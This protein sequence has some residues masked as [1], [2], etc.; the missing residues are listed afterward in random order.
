MNLYEDLLKAGYVTDKLKASMVQDCLE[1]KPVAG[2]LLRGDT[3]TGK[4]FL[5]YT[6][7][8]ILEAD[9]FYQQC[10]KNTG[11]EEL[12]RKILPAD[13]T[14]SGIKTTD[15]VI[16]QALK[17]S[18]DKKTI[19]FIDEIDK[20][21]PSCDTV[22]LELLQ[23]GTLHWDGDVFVG[24]TDNLTIFLGANEAR[25]LEEPLI[26][27]LP[28]IKFT[29]FTPKVVAQ[30]LSK[31][32]AESY[33]LKHILTLYEKYYIYA[34][35]QVPRKTI[36]VQEL[37]QALTLLT[38]AGTAI[39][40][41]E[42]ESILYS[43]VLK[44]DD[45]VEEFKTFAIIAVPNKL[46]QKDSLDEFVQKINEGSPKLSEEI[47]QTNPRKLLGSKF[48]NRL[49]AISADDSIFND[50]SAY[51]T[52]SSKTEYHHLANIYLKSKRNNLQLPN[53]ELPNEFT[54][55]RKSPI[56]VKYVQVAGQSYIV[57]LGS[58]L[59]NSGFAKAIRLNNATGEIVFIG[60]FANCYSDCLDYM[61]TL[62]DE[63]TS[64]SSAPK[65]IIE[66]VSKKYTRISVSKDRI[67]ATAEIKLGIIPGTDNDLQIK[68]G[69]SFDTTNC[70]IA[71]GFINWMTKI[72]MN[73]LGTP[74]IQDSNIVKPTTQTTTAKGISI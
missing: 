7:S 30:I 34:Q 25:I 38:K 43:T 27:R 35:E 71:Q 47:T 15:G 51:W 13:N 56:T 26:R 69:L 20:A 22:L 16:I 28:V 32:F 45:A 40:S 33:W 52:V 6:L 4:T 19:L 65:Y 63:D 59:V 62:A 74:L 58:I 64:N 70:G 57:C 54:I 42:F 23:S 67:N 2:A 53:N 1:L 36:T 66:E 44:S 55:G 46:E 17:N 73:K 8:S 41:D 9:V 11:E 31:E 10:Y 12:I 49:D 39:A 3:G 18:A 14:P 60:K 48:I 29:I 61:L 5:P 24:N 68:L 37:K 72:L 50:A 21:R